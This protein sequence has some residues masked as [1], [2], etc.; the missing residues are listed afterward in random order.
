MARRARQNY[1]RDGRSTHDG[2]VG[3]GLREENGGEGTMT[4]TKGLGLGKPATQRRL[5]QVWA[6][7][8][9]RRR[10]SGASGMGC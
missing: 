5:P 4:Q 3:E 2:Q 10:W 8:R 9:R 6:P 1:A 7:G